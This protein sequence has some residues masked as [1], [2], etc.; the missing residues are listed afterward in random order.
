MSRTETQRQALPGVDPLFVE[1]WSPRAF[2]PEPV[3]QAT[4]TRLFEAARWSPSCFNEQPW[5][6]YTSSDATFDDYLQ[7]LVEKNRRWAQHA[8]VLGFLVGKRQFTRTGK[9]NPSFAL[10]CG[11]AWMA[12]T[13]QARLEG[14]YTHGMAGIQHEA[15]AD[16][17]ALDTDSEAVM[18]G[19]AI[20]RM[21]DP[22]QLETDF[23]EQESPSDRMAL[24]TVWQIK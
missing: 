14:L 4:L 24:E 16:Y 6:F 12:M 1:R 11:A 3:D 8:P 5:R 13:L 17:L 22:Q 23:R 7:L 19:F 21:G 2:A 10:D 18:M 20:G 9:D 15:V